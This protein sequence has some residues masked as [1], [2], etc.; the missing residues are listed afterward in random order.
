MNLSNSSILLVLTLLSIAVASYSLG[1]FSI[2]DDK[3]RQAYDI[4]E[5]KEGAEN[6][7]R[8]VTTGHDDFVLQGNERQ[9]IHDLRRA[10]T[11]GGIVEMMDREERKL[12]L[13]REYESLTPSGLIEAI[14]YYSNSTEGGSRQKIS[15][16]IHYADFEN[17][18]EAL[19]MEPSIKAIR[20]VPGALVRRSIKESRSSSE[21]AYALAKEELKGENQQKAFAGILTNMSL[22]DPQ[23]AFDLMIG[24]MD[25]SRKTMAQ[26]LPEIFRNF[27]SEN[28]D[29]MPELLNILND[30]YIRQR[31]ATAV[32]EGILKRGEGPEA[33]SRFAALLTEGDRGFVLDRAVKFTQ[34]SS[35]EEGI[36]FTEALGS[37]SEELMRYACFNL[38]HNMCG[39]DAEMTANWVYTIEDEEARNRSFD[40]TM[41]QWLRSDLEGVGEW[42]NDKPSDPKLDIVVG[43]FAKAV[44]QDDPDAALEWADSILDEGVRQDAINGVIHEWGKVDPSG[45]AAYRK[46]LSN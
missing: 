4:S 33:V 45:A 19:K 27:S 10:G 26:V 8:S 2:S 43:K 17:L 5:R 41:K 14:E 12:A 1:R 15:E 38:A 35:F 11:M 18:A 24:D 42:L 39:V 37:A 9:I 28:A 3:P 31:S 21:W 23:K 34:F 46:T 7:D 32:M 40:V 29:G 44:A 16:M 13:E 30:K 36:A 6:L 22:E 25:V 20:G